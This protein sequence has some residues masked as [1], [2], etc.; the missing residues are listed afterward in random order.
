MSERDPYNFFDIF[1]A[2]YLR[3]WLRGINPLRSHSLLPRQLSPFLFASLIFGDGRGAT[4]S[5]NRAHRCESTTNSR[6][7]NTAKVTTFLV[8]GCFSETETALLLVFSSSLHNEGEQLGKPRHLVVLVDS[9]LLLIA[10]PLSLGAFYA[11]YAC[12]SRAPAHMSKRFSST[13]TLFT[14][15]FL[16][17]ER[18]IIGLFGSVL[19]SGCGV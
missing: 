14:K 18:I 16:A 15:C 9:F 11:F 5:Y 10:R 8:P 4:T 7:A 12:I 2:R 6:L 1:G 3:C 17:A 13:F 19:Q